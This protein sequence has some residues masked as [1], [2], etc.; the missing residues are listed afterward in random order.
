V[1]IR[2]A[3]PVCE[4][5]GRLDT[6]G[7]AEWRCPGCAHLVRLPGKVAPT[8]PTCA[9]CGNAELYRKKD[10]PHGL[11]M[12]ILLAACAASTVTYWLYD[13]VLTWAILLGSAAF[14]G[15]LYLWV[16]D[17]IVCYRCGAH[18]RGVPDGTEHQP[19]ELVIHERYRQERLRREQ[20]QAEQ[21]SN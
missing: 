9:V 6:S 15:L 5:P 1:N 4:H 14:D 2:F 11:G 3:C 7:A 18:H 19:F 10:F 16:K 8:L 12:G 13:K 17:V 20:L 21:N